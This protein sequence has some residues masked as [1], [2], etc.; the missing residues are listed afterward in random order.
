MLWSALECSGVLHSPQARRQVEFGYRCDPGE[1]GSYCF[2]VPHCGDGER[3]VEGEEC[4]DRNRIAGP[5]P[6]L[7]LS[8][9][10]ASLTP[11]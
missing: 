3:N 10:A 9:H 5:P 11:Y 7:V 2:R 4:D 6:P 1:E 8:G